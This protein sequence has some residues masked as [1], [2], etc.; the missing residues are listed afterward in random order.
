MG[1]SKSGG[2]SLFSPKMTIL[3]GF[4]LPLA[5]LA[6]LRAAWAL[7]IARSPR[8]LVGATSFN[9][10]ILEKSTGNNQDNPSKYRP[11][12]HVLRDMQHRTLTLLCLH[13]YAIDMFT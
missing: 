5:S 2:S 1:N 6:P 13:M 10:R 7:E 11:F 9:G 8:S 12:K 4:F 3:G